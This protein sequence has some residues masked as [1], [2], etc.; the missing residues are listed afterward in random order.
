MR[1]VVGL[2]SFL[3]IGVAVSWNTVDAGEVKIERQALPAAV[4]ATLASRYPNAELL[5][6]T[7]E[8]GKG[9]T[10]YEVEMKVAGHRVDV[11]IEPN[12]K[13]HEEEAEIAAGDLPDRVRAGLASSAQ[14]NWTIQRAER[15]TSGDPAVAPRFELLVVHDKARLEL[16]YA[17]NGRRLSAARV[18]AKE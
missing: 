12:G 15:I 5:H 7:R 1:R 9:V 2:F 13:L 8:T 11:L 3:A 17:A 14:S 16:V 10:F 18:G 6:F 4:N